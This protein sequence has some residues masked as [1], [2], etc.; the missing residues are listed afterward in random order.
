[1]VKN[2]QKDVVSNAQIVT[3]LL[4][5]TAPMRHTR[6]IIVRSPDV[7]SVAL[8]EMASGLAHSEHGHSL[9]AEVVP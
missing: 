9:R 6:T 2:V 8:I 5:P 7:P 3:P 4:N 1:M